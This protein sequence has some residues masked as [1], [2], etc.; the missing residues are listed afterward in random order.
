MRSPGVIDIKRRHYPS[1]MEAV[2]QRLSAIVSILDLF[3]IR[4]ARRKAMKRVFLILFGILT[5]SGICSAQTI[6]YFPQ[7]ADGQQG[8]GIVWSTFIVITN[9]AA[10]GTAMTAPAEG[11]REALPPAAGW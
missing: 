7:I 8:G 2:S 1:K 6:F 3:E 5:A 10:T 11:R 4:I 9:P